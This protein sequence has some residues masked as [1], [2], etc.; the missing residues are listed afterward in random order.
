MYNTITQAQ[1]RYH[2]NNNR[3]EK[4]MQKIFLGEDSGWK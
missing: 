3:Q 4:K 1:A 2:F